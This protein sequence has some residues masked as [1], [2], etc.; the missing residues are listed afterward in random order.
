LV[1]YSTQEK[2]ISFI[3]FLPLLTTAVYRPCIGKVKN[4]FS[5]S[6]YFSK[7]LELNDDF[8]TLRMRRRIQ[9]DIETPE[10]SRYFGSLVLPKCAE[11]SLAR[12]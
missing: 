10:T 6:E 3:H 11:F 9:E 5:F 4:F 7:K 8:V 1:N 12:A 2:R